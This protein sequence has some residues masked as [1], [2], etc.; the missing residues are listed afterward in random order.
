M[1]LR[2][3]SDELKKFLEETYCCIFTGKIEVD[4]LEPEQFTLRLVLNSD[5]VP[6]NISYN[7]SK[8]EFMAYAKHE[9]KRRRL[10]RVEYFY[11]FKDESGGA[12]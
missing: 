10:N 9:I 2:D 8:D 4:E 5:Y 11:G 12:N 1:I 7:G 3:E 6:I